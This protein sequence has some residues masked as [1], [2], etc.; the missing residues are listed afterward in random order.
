[1]HAAFASL[2]LTFAYG[3]GGGLEPEEEY[4]APPQCHRLVVVDVGRRRRSS[5]AVGCPLE[6]PFLPHSPRLRRCPRDRRRR[7]LCAYDT[8][9]SRRQLMHSS[10]SMIDIIDDEYIDLPIDIEAGG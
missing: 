9:A 3:G 7:P 4:I 6:R 1:M 2:S 10:S 8:I 5:R